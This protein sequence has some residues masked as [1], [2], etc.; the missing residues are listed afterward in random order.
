MTSTQAL[1]SKNPTSAPD[2][3]AGAS[4]K[5]QQVKMTAANLGDP[6]S[7]PRADIKVEEN[8]LQNVVL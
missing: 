6:S 1:T 3:H 4:E 7:I 2:R 8:Q 5:A